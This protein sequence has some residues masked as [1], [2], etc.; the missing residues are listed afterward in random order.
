LTDS[1]RH[2]IRNERIDMSLDDIIKL[3]NKKIYS[4]KPKN[5]P[6]KRRSQWSNFKK[7]ASGVTLK[8]S[9]WSSLNGSQW[10]HI[11]TMQEASETMSLAQRSPL[12]QRSQRNFAR[13]KCQ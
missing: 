3:D 11:I 4:S 13:G 12:H 1:V 9:Q 10:S 8:R 6:H 7:E 5:L 2:A